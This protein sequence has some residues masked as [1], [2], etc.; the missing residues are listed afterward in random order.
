MKYI[1]IK[2]KHKFKR[3]TNNSLVIVFIVHVKQYIIA[4]FMKLTITLYEAEAYLV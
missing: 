1:K 2:R 4:P 3:Q